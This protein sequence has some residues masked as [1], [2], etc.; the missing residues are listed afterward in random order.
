MSSPL[1]LFPHLDPHV[2]EILQYALEG[3]ELTTQDAEYLLSVTGSDTFAITAAAD[4][5]RRYQAGDKV[6]FV[7]NRNVNFTNI[8][9][10]SCR[11]C[12]FSVTSDSSEGYF[13]SNEEIKKRVLEAVKLGATEVCIQ[14]GIHPK[15]DLDTYLRILK[16]VRDADPNIHIHA[17]SPEEIRYAHQKSGESIESVLKAMR[18]AGLGSMP[19]TAAEILN[20][21]VRRIICPQKLSQRGRL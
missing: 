6:S 19:G 3:Q 1:A 11:F 18:E 9:V 2:A 20:D 15:N 5:I 10:N 14:G 8:C 12:A 17:F 16:T 4:I 13:L 21:R 7:I